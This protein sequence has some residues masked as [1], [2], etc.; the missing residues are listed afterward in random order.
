MN[1]AFHLIGPT[2]DQPGHRTVVTVLNEP[3]LAEACLRLAQHGF[4]GD[5]AYALRVILDKGKVLKND[6]Y[7]MVIQL[8]ES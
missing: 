3:N 4:C 5:P 2:V 8:P 6:E 7:V 1:K